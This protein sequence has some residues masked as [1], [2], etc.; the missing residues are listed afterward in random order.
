MVSVTT[1]P[2]A[3][4]FFCLYQM[5][6]IRGIRLEEV[7]CINGLKKLNLTKGH[8]HPTGQFGAV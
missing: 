5:L 8:P 1:T 6:A 3:F 7:T 2:H 4:C